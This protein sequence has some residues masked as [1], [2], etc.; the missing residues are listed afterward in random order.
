MKALVTG[1]SGFVG[2]RLARALRNRGEEV[3]GVDPRVGP[4][5]NRFGI[6]SK[7]CYGEQYDLV[8]HTAGMVDVTQ[9]EKDPIGAWEANVAE[10]LALA[11]Q[12]TVKKAF[13]H[14][15]SYAAL[16]P[17]ANI[18]GRVK[19]EADFWLSKI[20]MP[21][22]SVTLVNIYGVGC[23]GV[24]SRF[25]LNRNP[26]IRGDGHQVRDFV[27]IDDVV[28][29]LISI[30]TEAQL[31]VHR[32]AGE[33]ASIRKLA[34]LVGR[35]DLPHDEALSFEIKA[36][37]DYKPTIRAKTTLKEGIAKMAAEAKEQ[38]LQVYGKYAE[39]A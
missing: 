12:I 5:T 24:I 8:F 7:E 30:G 38:G 37:S 20:P 23:Q 25:L 2:S 33:R 26:R 6:A 4:E 22:A 31:G 15:A 28:D 36:P 10:S 3:I 32:I 29:I 11:R 21:Y 16:T 19:A 35:T 27:Y 13:V 18:Y 34:A 39:E 17:T 14:T 9:C 1:S